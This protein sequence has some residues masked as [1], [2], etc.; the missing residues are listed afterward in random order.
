M[1]LFNNN[2]NQNST[3]IMKSTF[4]EQKDNTYYLPKP[5]YY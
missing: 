1:G 4:Y 2:Y 5:K 3:Q